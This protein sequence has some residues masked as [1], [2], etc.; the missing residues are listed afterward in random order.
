MQKLLLPLALFVAIFTAYACTKSEDVNYEQPSTSTPSDSTSQT[1][2]GTS[3]TTARTS[4]A[5]VVYFSCT[6]NTESVAQRIAHI[7]PADIWRIE[8]M[9]P[10]SSADLNYNNASSRANLEQNDPSARPEIKT[11]CHDI[12][13]YDIIFLGYPIW[14]GKAPKIIFTFLE[15]HNLAGKTIVPFCTSGSSGI[16]SSDTELHNSAANA[17][18]MTGCRFATNTSNE[19]IAQWIADLNLNINDTTTNKTTMKVQ[20]TFNGNTITATM[21]D[22]A[23]GRDFVSRLPLDVT[24]EDFN[25]ITEKIFYPTPALTLQGVERGCAPT[26]G[27]ITIYEPWGNVAIFC[28][29]W[30][31]SSSLIKIGHIEGKG[32]EALSVAGNIQARFE[33]LP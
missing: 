17:T 5:L 16:G 18:W 3:D 20:I 27:D 25:N 1:E 14:W 2:N 7:A 32:I 6:G 11:L 19:S 9:V 33:R 13:Q 22:N 26:A 23:A 24:L 28:K 30:S 31:Y 12:D 8:P 10:Y 21:E 15:N 29:N 4:N